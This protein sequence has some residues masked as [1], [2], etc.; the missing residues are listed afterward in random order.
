[1]WPF[2][3]FDKIGILGEPR[4]IKEIKTYFEKNQGAMFDVIIHYEKNDQIVTLHMFNRHSHHY[5]LE[6]ENNIGTED[7]K[8]KLA[9][10]DASAPGLFVFYSDQFK[11]VQQIVKEGL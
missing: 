2:I 8:V 9:Y 4:S 6:F 10:L 11:D 1:M 5:T 3:E 7:D